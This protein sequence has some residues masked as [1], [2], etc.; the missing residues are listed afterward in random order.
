[1][2][3]EGRMQAQTVIGRI[4]HPELLVILWLH[5][6]VNPGDEE[7]DRACSQIAAWRRA[8][9]GDV[10]RL[11]QFIVSDGG[12]PNARQRS[13]SSHEVQAGQPTKIAV[14]T[15]VLTNPLKRGVATALTWVNPSIRFYEPSRVAEALQYLDLAEHA[16]AVKAGLEKLEPG[17]GTVNTLRMIPWAEVL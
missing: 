14:V 15:T 5:S 6:S 16:T 2:G 7:W 10:T 17:L 13:R 8:H 3:I 9:G 4:P 12:A 11:R 1:M